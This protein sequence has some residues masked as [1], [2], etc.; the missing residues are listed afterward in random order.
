[1][2]LLCLCLLL[3]L[4]SSHGLPTVLQPHHTAEELLEEVHAVELSAAKSLPAME[5]LET[6]LQG[7]IDNVRSLELSDQ[8]AHEQ[9]V[10]VRE[11]RVVSSKLVLKSEEAT[12]FNLTR[13]A[14][15]STARCRSLHEALGGT[16]REVIRLTAEAG[17]HN[18]VFDSEKAKFDAAVHEMDMDSELLGNISL[19]VMA[20]LKESAEKAGLEPGP[21]QH[22]ARMLMENLHNE[23][24][25]ARKHAE[26]EW[27]LT[28]ERLAHVAH[29]VRTALNITQDRAIQHVDA[30]TQCQAGLNETLK[31]Q[32]EQVKLVTA[33]SDALMEA[34]ASLAAVGVELD[35]RS[36]ARRM[37]VEFLQRTLDKLDEFK[38][39][40]DD[41]SNNTMPI[42]GTF[43]MSDNFQCTEA[44]DPTQEYSYVPVGVASYHFD[45]DQ[46]VYVHY[47]NHPLGNLDDGSPV[48]P[49]K[50]FTTMSYDP[51]TREL[52]AKLDWTPASF[53]G[54]ATLDYT[55]VFNAAL[56]AVVDG[57]I[58]AY[59]KM[60][61]TIGQQNFGCWHYRRVNMEKGVTCVDKFKV[62]GVFVQSADPEC[63]GSNPDLAAGYLT[64]GKASLHLDSPTD[65]YVRHCS[66]NVTV[67]DDGSP[68][69]DRK[70]L[71]NTTYNSMLNELS[72][73]VDW[74]PTSLHG[75]S[76]LEY[77]LG[78]SDDYGHIVRG[79]VK[80]FSN[81]G[82][83]I[84]QTPFGCWH[85]KR[86]SKQVNASCAYTPAPEE[87]PE[88]TTDIS[89][90]AVVVGSNATVSANVTG[91]AN[92]TVNQTKTAG[93]AAASG[94]APTAALPWDVQCAIKFKQNGGCDAGVY[95]TSLVDS[96]IPWGCFHPSA[97]EAAHFLCSLIYTPPPPPPPSAC[98]LCVA[99]FKSA[100]G[101]DVWGTPS[102]HD[103]IPEVC[104]GCDDA[105]DQC[106]AECGLS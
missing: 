83:I 20:A 71:I 80:G 55:M 46:D 29:P 8:A 90:P 99:G 31:R 12:L 11:A 75:V 50:S 24:L 2:L 39:R 70:P 56:D 72:A 92:A 10:K 79:D 47:C 45:S 78:F 43:V 36:K 6:E 60:G 32:S 49:K 30:L 57:H 22:Q 87:L 17:K 53:D 104:A 19:T 88:E 14:N 27:Q 76:R 41:S 18:S 3:G 74:S 34:D 81:S 66:D 106:K 4:I 37:R 100:G 58:V 91:A 96:R 61:N 82:R 33:A 15:I 85:Y 105:E 86:V 95:G 52:K 5:A 65:I 23:L 44:Y 48:P 69:P 101:C 77:N 102:V 62:Q 67:L 73:V 42:R 25:V 35:Q 40:G 59:D 26:I 54:I 21:I 63:V 38:S 51:D 28:S 13:S 68:L 97:E 94:S 16:H 98:A 89:E 64:V 103:L 84:S 9:E 1:M 7:D 93:S